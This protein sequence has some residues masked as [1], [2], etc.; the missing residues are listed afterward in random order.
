MATVFD[1]SY[2]RL[3]E[4]FYSRVAPTP[5]HSPSLLRFNQALAEEIGLSAG[6]FPPDVLAGNALPEGANPIALAYAGH[7]FGGWV[8]QLGD[9]R[10]ILLGEVIGPDGRR[11]DIQ[12]KGSGPTI[13]SRNGDGRAALGPA[14]REYVVSEAMAA[15]G[16]PTTRALA[17]ATTGEKV[18]RERP[19]PGAVFT[20]VASSHVRVGTF[21]YH[22]ARGD[23]EALRPQVLDVASDAVAELIQEAR[24]E[25][26]E[27]AG[28]VAAGRLPAGR[29]APV[30]WRPACRHTATSV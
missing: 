22:H 26:G 25:A 5:V 30:L 8:P 23:L 28:V 24:V 7:Q 27:R 6:D 20:R 29:G 12:L 4:H 11:H 21:Q 13:F 2:A 18:L 17:V 10:A 9:G 3:P 16:I 14:I 15:L 19:L 1:N